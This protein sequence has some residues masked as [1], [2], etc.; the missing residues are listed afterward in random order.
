MAPPPGWLGG[1]VPARIVLARGPELLI[2]LGSMHAYPTG[3]ELELQLVTR[4]PRPDLRFFGDEDSMRLGVAFA[5]GRKWQGSS[6]GHWRESPPGPVLMFRGGSGSEYQRTQNL[7][8]W[9]LP[10]PG[11]VTFALAWPGQGIAEATGEI[12]GQL[13]RAAATEAEKLWEPLSPEEQE[14]AMRAHRQRM[15]ASAGGSYG[16]MVGYRVGPDPDDQK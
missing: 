15:L 11:P 6:P 1:L 14:A 3:V 16:T 10:P 8:L 7:W 9:P 5:D 2:T 4:Q 13:L 12:D